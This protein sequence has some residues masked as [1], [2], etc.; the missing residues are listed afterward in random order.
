MPHFFFELIDRVFLPVVLIL[1]GS[2]KYSYRVFVTTWILD[3]IITQIKGN[4]RM[5]KRISELFSGI[6]PYRS[7]YFNLM[8]S[9]NIAFC[10][11]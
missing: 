2:G 11:E 5:G 7:K 8:L 3:E 6:F 1:L 10:L 9:P 4:D